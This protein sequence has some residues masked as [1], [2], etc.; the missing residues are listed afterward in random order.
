VP[1]HL[2]SAKKVKCFAK[3]H[4]KLLKV[5]ID[6]GSDESFLNKKHVKHGKVKS[7]NKPSKWVTGAGIVST[8]RKCDVTFKLNEFSNSKEIYWNFNVDETSE[9]SDSLKYDM[10]IGLDLMCKL[11]I[12]L[13]CKSKIVKWDKMKI[14]MTTERGAVSEKKYKPKS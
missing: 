13:D 2:N 5:L 3:T 14:P 11:G 4:K 8:T 12:I 7:L 6:S 10:I 9:S 1:R